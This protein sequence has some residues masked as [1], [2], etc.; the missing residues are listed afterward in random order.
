MKAGDYILCERCGHY[1]KIT[2]DLVERCRQ[3]GIRSVARSRGLFTCE[4]CFDRRA[5]LVTKREYDELFRA[6]RKKR[7]QRPLVKP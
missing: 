1:R 4:K 6:Y 2:P 7:A 3:T 5:V